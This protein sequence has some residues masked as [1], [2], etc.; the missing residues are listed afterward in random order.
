MRTL[1]RRMRSGSSVGFL[2]ERKRCVRTGIKIVK[3]T[4]DYY[5]GRQHTSLKGY[6]K[7]RR[8][9]N[10]RTESLGASRYKMDGLSPQAT[11]H[12][13]LPRRCRFPTFLHGQVVKLSSEQTK[14]RLASYTNTHKNT[15][16]PSASSSPKAPAE[17][18]STRKQ[19]DE[20]RKTRNHF[21][22]R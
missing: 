20:Y 17:G 2:P 10:S 15:T 6:L 18:S 19:F 3:R 1:E 5:N 12:D 13:A 16:S 8:Q 21:C 7:G 22:S 11:A 9:R 14:L 4:H